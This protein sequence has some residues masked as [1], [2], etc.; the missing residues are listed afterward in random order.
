MS[1]VSIF[2][3]CYILFSFSNALL[4]KRIQNTNCR[5]WVMIIFGDVNW[6][7]FQLDWLRSYT[8]RDEVKFVMQK[9]DS[10]FITKS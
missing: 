2:E 5:V 7:D 8:W 3:V 10:D 4:S 6:T 9:W 1:D